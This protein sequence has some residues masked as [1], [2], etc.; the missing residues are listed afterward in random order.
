MNR[1]ASTCAE[2]YQ[3]LIISELK[4]YFLNHVKALF[5]APSDENVVDSHFNLS[6]LKLPSL[7]L[8]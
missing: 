7:L 2:S 6:D 8:S 1:N 5:L 4:K 3:A